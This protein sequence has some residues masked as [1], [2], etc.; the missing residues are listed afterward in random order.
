M[1]TMKDVAKRAG[2][3]TYTVSNVLNN[4]SYLKDETKQKVLT[5]IRELDYKPNYAGKLLR[6]QSTRNIG[7]S[8][9]LLTG[10]TTGNDFFNQILL[11][12]FVELNKCNYNLLVSFSGNDPVIDKENFEKYND[13]MIAGMISTFMLD[14]IDFLKSIKYPIV[15]IDHKPSEFICDYV[16]TN[17][18]EVVQQAVNM[19]IRKGHK[20]IG[21]I[22]SNYSNHKQSNHCDRL[23]G[24]FSAMKDNDIAV[25][26]NWVYSIN[27]DLYNDLDEGYT[28]TGKLYKSGVSA[29]FVDN[30]YS[31][32]GLYKYAKSAGLK[33]PDDLAVIA[34]DDYQWQTISGPPMSVIKQP[35]EEI[36]KKAVELLLARI[37]DPFKN[38]ET[39]VLPC[40][41][42]EREST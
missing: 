39:V 22:G 36:G 13:Q 40:K 20:K 42:V 27:V 4:L 30:T 21:Y 11:A 8:M 15:A 35:T 38:V 25:N 34:F 18:D 12:I 32:I 3:S 16:V 7:V 10:S 2:V 31:A 14:D 41:I 1:A 26:D 17:N 28:A 6:T 5:A 33:I 19:L 9:P 24:Y 23:K 37:E 29:V